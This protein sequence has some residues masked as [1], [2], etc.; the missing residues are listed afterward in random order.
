[1]NNDKCI[2]VGLLLLKTSFFSESELEDILSCDDLV[3]NDIFDKFVPPLRRF[4]PML[5]ARI[6]FELKDYLTYHG[7]DG[8]QVLNWC[9]QQFAEVARARYLSNRDTRWVFYYWLF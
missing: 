3:L 9:H 1:L 6:K 5:W 7:A 8:V 4:P 2:L